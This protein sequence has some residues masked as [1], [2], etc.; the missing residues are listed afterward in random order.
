MIAEQPE[1]KTTARY[2]IRETCELL[3]IHRHTLRRYTDKGLIRCGYR[4][5]N[6]A[7]YT[8]SEILRLWRESY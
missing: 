5:T 3:K 4:K 1:V 2:S 8:G 6:H 7:Y